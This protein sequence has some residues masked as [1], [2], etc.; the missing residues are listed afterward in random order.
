MDDVSVETNEVI[1]FNLCFRCDAVGCSQA[2]GRP[3]VDA[4]IEI[5]FL[6]LK[7]RAFPVFWR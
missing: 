5:N 1:S 4:T 2:S 7:R 6:V 3:V